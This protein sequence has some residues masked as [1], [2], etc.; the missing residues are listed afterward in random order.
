MGASIQKL[1]NVGIALRPRNIGFRW[2]SNT[3]YVSTSATCVY[4]QRHACGPRKG[5][6][7]REA[8]FRSEGA[9]QGDVFF[10]QPSGVRAP[11]YKIKKSISYPSWA[12]K[13]R[14]T[15]P[16]VF[17]HRRFSRCSL[18]APVAGLIFPPSPI[19]LV[20]RCPSHRPF[21]LSL[22]LLRVHSLPGTLSGEARMGWCAR[23]C[24][25]SGDSGGDDV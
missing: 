20:S 14:V 2:C 12:K 19:S 22:F 10:W 7:G 1:K 4:T 23:E 25:N 16:V 21:F 5:G 24:R 8:S 13:N 18:T 17:H 6:R 11:N 9:L 15:T 3:K